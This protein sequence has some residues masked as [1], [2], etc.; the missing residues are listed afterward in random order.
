MSAVS[1]ESSTVV[2]LPVGKWKVDPDRSELLFHTRAMFGLFRV[3]GSFSR[4][5]GGF[6]SDAGGHVTGSLDVEVETIST[7]IPRRDAHLRT[8]DFFG[9]AAE[10]TMVFALNSATAAADGLVNLSGDLRIRTTT[11]PITVPTTVGL[12]GDELRLYGRAVVDHHSAGLG[13]AK[14][15]MV[16]KT[17]RAEIGLLLTLQEPRL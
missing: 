12:R 1:P 16:R 11:V 13:W 10:P 3:I 8:D 2:P 17:V 9:A 5:S 6:E 7:G 4:F 15:G 14:P